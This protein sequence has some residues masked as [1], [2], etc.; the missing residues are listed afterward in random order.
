M[1][2]R[3]KRPRLSALARLSLNA[4]VR[5][6]DMK[7]PDKILWAVFLAALL[8][9]ILALLVKPSCYSLY[10][11]FPATPHT[12]IG[13]LRSVAGGIILVSGF[14]VA[15][16]VAVTLAW[17]GLRRKRYLALLCPIVVLANPFQ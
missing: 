13:R 16:L 6:E 5:P 17:R 2:S 4:D 1:K 14:A 11:F 7:I 9:P 10:M 3:I 15:L 12:A 8:S